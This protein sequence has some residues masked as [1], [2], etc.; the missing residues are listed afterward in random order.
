[1]ADAAAEREPA[2][3]GVPERAA[4]KGEAD[5]LTRWIDVLPK[6]AA[7]ACNA[8]RIA[9]DDDAA[10]QT[11]IDDHRTI[12]DAM[13]GDAVTA[14]A[15]GNGKIRLS[16]VRD[17]RNDVVDVEWSNDQ[18]RPPV[19]HAVERDARRVVVAV[20]RHLSPGRGDAP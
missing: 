20:R 4:G 17:C 5:T 19:D 9:I 10:H 18:L 13:P 2:D 11:E 14:A 8:L 7:A 16:G 6:R 3:A 15:N 1:M 12:T